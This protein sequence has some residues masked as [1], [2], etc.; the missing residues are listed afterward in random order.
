MDRSEAAARLGLSERATAD[1]IR[2]AFRDRARAV[3]PDAGG[4][5]GDLDRLVE[6]RDVLLRTAPAAAPNPAAPRPSPSAPPK[7]G[8]AGKWAWSALLAAVAVVAVAIGVVVLVGILTTRGDDR[9]A[10]VPADECVVLE[11]STALPASCDAEDSFR[12]VSR[13]SGAQTCP[14][15]QDSLVVGSSTW[16]L[17]RTG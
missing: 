13:L 11:R 16:C 15:G 14:A 5:R 12:V 2:N 4:V 7:P 10:T 3:H 9:D 8:R 1:D 17:E 6:A